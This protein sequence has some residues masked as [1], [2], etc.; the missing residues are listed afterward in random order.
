MEDWEREQANEFLDD[1]ILEMLRHKAAEFQEKNHTIIID[2]VKYAEA[3]RA[4]IEIKKIVSGYLSEYIPETESENYDDDG[5]FIDPSNYTA[6]FDEYF[7]GPVLSRSLCFRVK[8]PPVGVEFT[9][10][11]IS[12]ICNILPIGTCVEIHPSFKL[13]KPDGIAIIEFYFRDIYTPVFD[14]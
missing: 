14:N 11:D 9:F 4:I 8:I 5:N 7:T 10:D 6:E 2:P 1:E 12:R 3:C 13:D